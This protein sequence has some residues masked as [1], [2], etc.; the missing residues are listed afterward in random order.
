MVRVRARV[1][2]R[3]AA[4]VGVGVGVRRRRALS[5]D[6]PLLDH[7][8]GQARLHRG[9]RNGEAGDAS[10]NDDDVLDLVDQ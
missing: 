5:A 2:V 1:G 4:R 7:L 8:Y 6:G 9:F 10:A 3:V